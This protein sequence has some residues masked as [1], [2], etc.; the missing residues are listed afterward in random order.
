MLENGAGMR[1][2][3]DNERIFMVVQG[4]EAYIDGGTGS[5]S[6][7]GKKDWGRQRS[8]QRI[9]MNKQP[10]GAHRVDRTMVNVNKLNCCGCNSAHVPDLDQLLLTASLSKNFGQTVYPISRDLSS[11]YLTLYL[12][13]TLIFF[14]LSLSS[15]HLDLP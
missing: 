2:W 4:K 3:R 10:G 14:A 11:L 7:Y 15:R 1:G 9:Y 6:V 5:R 13:N 8:P 12:V